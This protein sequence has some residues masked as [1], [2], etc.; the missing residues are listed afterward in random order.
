MMTHQMDV[1][2]AH[3]KF[4]TIRIRAQKTPED[5][6]ALAAAFLTAGIAFDA[7]ALGAYGA[8]ERLRDLADQIERETK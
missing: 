1:Y 8:A 2:A 6:A 5:A 3:V 4:F 7:Q